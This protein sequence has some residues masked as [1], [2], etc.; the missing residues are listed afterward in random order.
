MGLLTDFLSG[1][2]NSIA[3]NVSAP[4]D[5]LTWLLRKAGVAFIQ[6]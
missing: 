3:S 2:S 6:F 4:V 1:T 5:G